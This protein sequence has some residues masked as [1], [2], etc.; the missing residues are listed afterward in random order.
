M[1]YTIK[2]QQNMPT[3]SA[4]WDAPSWQEA[5]TLAITHFPWPDS[6]HRPRVQA[7]AL[8]DAVALYIHFRVED[9]YVRAVAENFQDSVCLDSCV[10]FFVA[11]LT[12][13]D[14]YFNFEVNCG[15]TMLLHRC[16]SSAE[17]EAGGRAEDVSDEDGKT[18]L[19]AHS[20]PKI[21]EPE[22]TEKTIWTVEY[23]IPFA[24]FSKYF[25]APIPQSGDQWRA[26]FYKCGDATSHPHW[27]SW[28]L[29]E[30]ER[31]NFH[32]PTFF[33]PIIFA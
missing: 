8:Y 6:G 16:L 26:N 20:L 30:T 32:Q 24:L 21:V 27:G 11:P 1:Q 2:K 9:Q 12:N 31:P 28:A 18:I 29:V 5:E 19:M 4:D 3:P 23:R 17:R 25:A 10:E 14:A 7:R 22:R 15:G 13:S 33:Q